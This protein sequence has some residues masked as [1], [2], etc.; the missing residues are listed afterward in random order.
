MEEGQLLAD[1]FIKTSLFCPRQNS[2]TYTIKPHLLLPTIMIGVAKSTGTE[3]FEIAT[4]KAVFTNPFKWSIWVCSTERSQQ[5]VHTP[6][7]SQSPHRP[8]KAV[9]TVY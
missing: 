2:V 7:V 5:R 6:T 3:I 9:Y 8:L 4:L 1:F